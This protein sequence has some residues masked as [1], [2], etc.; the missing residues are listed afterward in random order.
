MNA[1]IFT[2]GGRFTCFKRTS[3]LLNF[4]LYC[5]VFEGKKS[6]SSR[7][8]SKSCLFM[9]DNIA[10]IPRRKVPGSLYSLTSVLT[11]K[12]RQ[13]WD[14]NTILSHFRQSFSSASTYCWHPSSKRLLCHRGNGYSLSQSVQNMSPILSRCPTYRCQGRTVM[15]YPSS[16]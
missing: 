13:W 3:T 11:N 14:G 9:G 7:W 15:N 1:Q 5:F 16:G 10:S 2:V 12:K 4:G 6:I 8:S